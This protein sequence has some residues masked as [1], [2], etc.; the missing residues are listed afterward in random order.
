MDLI[1]K[2][3]ALTNG[4]P[5]GYL[6]II[7]VG[8][9]IGVK[10]VGDSFKR[11]MQAGIKT[12]NSSFYFLLDGTKTEKNLPTFDLKQKDV[13]S[14]VIADGDTLVAKSGSSMRLKEVKEHFAD[15]EKN[16]ASDENGIDDAKEIRDES[17]KE[18][19]L[20]KLSNKDGAEYYVGIKENLDELFIVHPKEENLSKIFPESEWVRI[21]YEEDEYYVVGKIKEQGR[22]VLIGYG[23]PGKKHLSPPKVADGLF[24][25]V[26]VDN[27]DEYDGYWILFQDANSGKLVTVGDAIY[28]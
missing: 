3:V 15:V 10:V 11:G 26:S 1:K 6:S 23:V 27:M 16:D 18:E 24:N 17:D 2:T 22:I 14:C 25:W 21:N 13:V 28:P 5:I 12:D 9:D 7:K 19:L 4:E 20:V 8:E